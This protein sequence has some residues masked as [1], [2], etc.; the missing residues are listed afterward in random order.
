MSLVL[1]SRSPRRQQL[2]AAL[3][4]KFEVVTADV[5]E[6]ARKNEE[7]ETM[8]LRLA[9]SKARQVFDIVGKDH[10]VIGGDTAVA[11][12]GKIMG[13]PRNR[14]HAIAMLTELSGRTHRVLS[15]VA[16]VEDSHC[17]KRLS[18]SRVTFARLSR[19]QIA[20]YCDT[21]DPY[22]KAG[23]YGIQGE[24]GKFVTALVGSYSG[25]VGLPLW[26]LHQLLFGQVNS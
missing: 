12:D 11:L 25:V 26:H 14:E 16:L 8:T 9:E 19:Q 5:V 15:A 23:A 1:A 7:P 6:K 22:D 18:E 3:G 4:L 10:R 2:L 17:R 24:A 20:R 13:K 21:P